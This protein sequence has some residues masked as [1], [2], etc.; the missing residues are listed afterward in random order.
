MEKGYV[1]YLQIT[2]QMENTRQYPPE[3]I[4][5]WLSRFFLYLGT[6]LSNY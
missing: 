2:T 3:R 5:T 4:L 1:F 6:D